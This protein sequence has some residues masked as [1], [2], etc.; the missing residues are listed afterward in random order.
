[1]GPILIL[2]IEQPGD[3]ARRAR[4]EREKRKVWVAAKQFPGY[5]NTGGLCLTRQCGSLSELEKEVARLKAELDA[6]VVQ[7]RDNGIE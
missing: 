1:M 7:A 6:V 4:F 3:L 2:G 5:E